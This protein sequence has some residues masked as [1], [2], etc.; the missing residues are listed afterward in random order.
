M[1]KFS[2]Y[3]KI[4]AH[5]GKRDELIQLLLECNHLMIILP[6]KKGKIHKQ[7]QALSYNGTLCP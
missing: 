3:G 1:N 6:P 7:P 4:T 5:P 2:M